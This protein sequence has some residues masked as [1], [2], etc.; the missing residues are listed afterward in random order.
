MVLKQIEV[1]QSCLMPLLFHVHQTAPTNLS[2]LPFVQA[3]STLH[4]F[5]SKRSSQ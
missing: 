4:C 3:V 2:A 5:S 1:E